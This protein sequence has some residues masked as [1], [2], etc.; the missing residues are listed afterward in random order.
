VELA[1]EFARQGSDLVLV[2]RREER[3]VELAERLRDDHGVEAHPIGRDLS[4]PLAAEILCE[5]LERRELRVDVLV[6]NAGF[7]ARGKV[8]ELPLERQ[9]D[10]IQLNVT[11]LVELTRRL[12]PPMLERGRGGVLNVSST[13]AFLSG[14]RMSVYFATKAFV[15]SFT[16]GLH[17]ELRGT[18]VT[19]TALCP[20]ATATEFGAASGMSET[21]LFERIAVD[22]GPV[23][24]TG[25][26][27]FR[28]GRASVVSGVV[29]KL[30]VLNTR[31]IP[32]ALSRRLVERG[33][34]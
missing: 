30:G 25:V 31:L 33:L 29:N 3:L 20:G 10:M 15:Q 8:H 13:A 17:E 5:E 23:A 27:A 7:G 32:R 21:P 2:A 28:A 19:A 18:G 26:A 14:P 11:T 4:E 34:R 9:L 16:E 1:R 12:L 6:N 22:P 24:R